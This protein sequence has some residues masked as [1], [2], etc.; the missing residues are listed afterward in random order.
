MGKFILCAGPLAKE[1]YHFALTNTNVYSLEELGYYLYHNIYTISL[2]TFDQA[3]FKWVAFELKREDLAEKWKKICEV[4][5]DIKDIVVSILCATDYFTKLEIESLIKTVDRINGLLPVQRKKMEADNYLK[6][7]EYE[8]ALQVYKEIVM[9]DSAKQLSAVDFGNMLHNMAVIHVQLKAFEQAEREFK[10][11]YSL[12]Q[13]EESLREY[14]YLLKLQQKETE[15]MQQVLEYDLSEE[16][17]QSFIEGLDAVYEQAEQTK[18]YKKIMG[19]PAMKEAGKVGD[20]YYA[21][22]TMI[23]QWKQQYKH[24]MEQE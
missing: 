24:G 2:R 14:F 16:K 17:V 5:S 10:Q 3:F 19:L 11:A 4:S 8:K 20:Y 15:F 13:N 1:P 22:D 9:S 18:E 6:Y 12:N 23:F 7:E 21:I